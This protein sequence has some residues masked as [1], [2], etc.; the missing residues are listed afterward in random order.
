MR[1]TANS[2]TNSFLEQTNRLTSRQQELQRRAASGLKFQNIEE[3]PTGARQV[4]F[5]QAESA[6]ARQYQDNINSEQ[7][8]ATAVCTA[9]RNLKTISDRAR[10][11]STLAD[12]LRSPQELQAYAS[13][14]DLLIKQA[15]QV[16][17]TKQNAAYLFAG[18]RSDTAPFEVSEVNGQVASVSYVGNQESSGVF[19]NAG[20]Q[21]SAQVPGANASGVGIRGVFSDTRSGADIF[22]HL[23]SLRDHLAF[24]DT[25]AISTT[26]TPQLALDEDN[27]L[28]HISNAA[29]IQSR[30]QGFST[31]LSQRQTDLESQTTRLTAADVAETMVQ[32]SSTM[33][34]YQA[35]LQSAAKIMQLNLGDFL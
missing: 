17:N 3:N 8:R 29:V 28:F 1:V 23:I 33:T 19:V 35:A 30:L 6:S 16:A 20:I 24:G 9:A 15:L 2:F 22:A 34:T 27:V 7:D 14:V 5:L 11:I 18:T 26:D 25:A 21:M 12:D 32:L 13:E 10:E 4:L 31:Q